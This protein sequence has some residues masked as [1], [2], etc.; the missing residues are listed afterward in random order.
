MQN[1]VYFESLEELTISDKTPSSTEVSSKK[2]EEE[3]AKEIVDNVEN[4][5]LNDSITYEEL[6][7]SQR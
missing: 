1:H 7:D 4:V 5:P 3:E 6:T 2:F